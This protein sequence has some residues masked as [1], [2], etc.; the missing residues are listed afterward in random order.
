MYTR[1][2]MEKYWFLWWCECLGYHF[3]LVSFNPFVLIQPS[4]CLKFTHPPQWLTST[5]KAV[6]GEFG[7]TFVVKSR[8]VERKCWTSGSTLVDLDMNET[9][10]TLF[11]MSHYLYISLI[12]KTSK[13]TFAYCF[14]FD[15]C[16]IKKKKTKCRFVTM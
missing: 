14:I 8:G 16:V 10:G 2:L 3:D 1:R 5:T 13:F 4:F 6:R 11:S 12:F 7:T 15:S 9:M